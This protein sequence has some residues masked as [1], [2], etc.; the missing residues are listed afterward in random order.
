M[1]N[2]I[3]LLLAIAL[4]LCVLVS[5]FSATVHK[6]ASFYAVPPDSSQLAV[7]ALR[8]SIVGARNR[9]LGLSTQAPELLYL[10]ARIQ[11]AVEPTTVQWTC[12]NP[13]FFNSKF[14]VV[15]PDVTTTYWVTV[16]DALGRIV[17]ESHSKHPNMSS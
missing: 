9:I 4:Q 6:S 8:V 2:R 14:L 12:A 10:Y 17:V 5:G 7:E 3:G 1:S 11:G 13:I 15:D 16:T